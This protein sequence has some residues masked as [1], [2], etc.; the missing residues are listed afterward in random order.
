MRMLFSLLTLAGTS[1]MGV[2]PWRMRYSRNAPYVR[3][4]TLLPACDN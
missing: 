4:E 1:N 3:W 2:G